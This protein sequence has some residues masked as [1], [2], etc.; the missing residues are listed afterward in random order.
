ML[1][2]RDMYRNLHYPSIASLFVATVG[3]VLPCETI[4]E[5]KRADNAIIGCRCAVCRECQ[6]KAD[7]CKT[8]WR[9]ILVL[10][11]PNAKVGGI[12]G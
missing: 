4:P 9:Y 12:L 3:T 10:E 11:K 6:S 7:H 5:S 2:G 8:Q 1:T